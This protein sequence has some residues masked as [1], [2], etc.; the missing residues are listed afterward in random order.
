MLLSAVNTSHPVVAFVFPTLPGYLVQQEA[1]GLRTAIPVSTDYRSSG[2]TLSAN[3][4]TRIGL[5]DNL[6]LRNI[7][8]YVEANTVYQFDT[9]GTNLPIFDALDKPR[10]QTLQQYTEEMQILGKAFGARLDWILGGFYLDSRDQHWILRSQNAFRQHSENQARGG[11]KS[12]AVFAQGT[13]D[14]SGLLAGLSATAGVRHTWDSSFLD[15]RGPVPGTPLTSAVCTEPRVNCDFLTPGKEGTFSALTWTAGLDYKVSADTLLY[16]ASRRGYRPGGVNPPTSGI[17]VPDFDPEYVSDVEL[18][19]KSDWI[20]GSVPVRTNAAL[21][22]QDYSDAQ[23]TVFR[24]IS[25]GATF[26]NTSFIANAASARLWGAE[27]EAQMKLTQR[28]ELGVN[29]D[30]L[31]FKYTDFGPGANALDLGTTAKGNRPPYKYGVSAQYHLPLGAQIGAVSMRAN[32]V[33]QDDSGDFRQ[34]AG[35]LIPAY[36]LLNLS[37]NWANV[38]GQP[39]DVSIFVSNATNEEYRTGGLGIY[40]LAGY[41]VTRYGEPRMYGLRLRYSFGEW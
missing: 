16:L 20:V 36:G 33:W 26:V 10:D 41:N 3:N 39:L 22:Y 40:D 27:L 38:G 13:Y 30:Y 28:L 1:A 14:L 32:W 31:N 15:V 5:T 7:L 4:T 6:T 29:F 9:D 8:G 18:G 12:K 21:Y 19:I 37:A 11:S 24:V 35:G 17:V 25:T 34:N 2:T 23:V